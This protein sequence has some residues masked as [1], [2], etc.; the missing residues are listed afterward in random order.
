MIFAAP[1]QTP[2]LKSKLVAWAAMVKNEF[3][4]SGR[5]VAYLT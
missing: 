2:L 3:T 4:A 5:D 1:R